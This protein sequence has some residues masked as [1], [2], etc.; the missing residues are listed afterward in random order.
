MPTCIPFPPEIREVYLDFN[1]DRRAVW[2]LDIDPEVVD[3]R[4]LEWHLDLPFWSSR[5]PEMLFDLVPR[6][7]M[8]D[9]TLAPLHTLRIELADTAFPLDVMEHKADV[10]H[11]FCKPGEIVRT[12]HL[13]LIPV[14]SDLFR[15]RLFFRDSLRED[16]EL[17][18]RYTSLKQSLAEQFPNDREA[19]TQAKGPFVAE[20]VARMNR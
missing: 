20:V 16:A 8:A 11:W 15:E 14:D 3:C 6:A 2:A 13:H 1:R 18:Q 7:V 5:R 4:V 12:H 9:A 17:R 19:Y 10:M